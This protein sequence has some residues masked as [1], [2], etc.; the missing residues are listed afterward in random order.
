MV[1]IGDWIIFYFNGEIC[2]DKLFLIYWLIVIFYYFFGINEW[3]VC[4]LLVIFG[5]GLMCFGF[6]IF[7]RYG[8]YYL[9]F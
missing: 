7:Y 8:Y 3:F 1:K 4:F 6:Y 2:F 9:N 5:I